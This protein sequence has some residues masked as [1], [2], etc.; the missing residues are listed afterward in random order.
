MIAG[1]DN[2]EHIALNAASAEIQLTEDELM[3]IDRL[4]L[5]D[6][7]RSRPPIFRTQPPVR[8]PR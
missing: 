6:E 4:T 7:D 8:W 1:A 2:A 3:E 5:I